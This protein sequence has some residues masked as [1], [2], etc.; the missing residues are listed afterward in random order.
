M[1]KDFDNRTAA[2]RPVL[3]SMFVIP[4]CVTVKFSTCDCPFAFL[5]DAG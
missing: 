1:K 3:F 4:Y 5:T 2:G